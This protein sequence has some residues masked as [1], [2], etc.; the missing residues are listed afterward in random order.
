MNRI[1]HLAVAVA[2]LA[3]TTALAGP[4]SR[5]EDVRLEDLM[6]LDEDVSTRAPMTEREYP[7]TITIV[8]RE[9]IQRMAARD[10]L[11]VLQRIPGFQAGLD[12]QG[13]VALA[14]RGQWS[15]EG[16]VLLLLDGQPMN[17]PMYGMTPLGGRFD[18]SQVQRIEIIRGPG[19][20]KYGFGATAA[21]INIVTV[22]SEGAEGGSV[23]LTGCMRAMGAGCTLGGV[24]F[25]HQ[26]D[27]VRVGASWLAGQARLFGGRY[28]DFYGGTQ[29]FMA[30]PFLR[31]DLDDQSSDAMIDA[32]NALL[33]PLV[34]PIYLDDWEIYHLGLGEVHCGSNVVR[35]PSNEDW[36]TNDIGGNK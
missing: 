29:L 9:E 32:V 28:T 7:G 24:T 5:I 36:G 15:A 30:D 27:R 22:M 14:V 19:A 21:A 11:D 18:L 20:S 12:V 35:T 3:T 26:R 1:A 31:E 25:V 33:P 16:R 10:L 4:G 2:T 6:D 23:H 34:T 17:E 8:H 13:V